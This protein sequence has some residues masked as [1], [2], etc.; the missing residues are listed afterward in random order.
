LA[1]I[2]IFIDKIFGTL[3]EAS[4]LNPIFGVWIPNVAFGILAV[5]LLNN[6]KR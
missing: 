6:A 4:T 2:Y 3:A 1:F 5:Y